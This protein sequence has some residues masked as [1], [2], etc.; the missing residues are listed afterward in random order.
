MYKTDVV[1]VNG[2]PPCTYLYQVGILSPFLDP[3]KHL[4]EDE[5]SEKKLGFRLSTSS[6][7][8][9]KQP[10]L[11]GYKVAATKNCVPPPSE[12]KGNEP[13]APIE[14]GVSNS[15]VPDGLFSNQKSQF[16]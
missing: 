12:L 13:V 16:G 3:W 6:G 7:Q 5:E 9:S 15:G 10:L 8:A 2:S 14:I 1:A 11:K 4:L